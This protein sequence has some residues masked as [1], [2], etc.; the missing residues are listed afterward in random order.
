[1]LGFVTNPCE[2]LSRRLW[3]TFLPLNHLQVPQRN[4]QTSPFTFSRSQTHSIPSKPNSFT[5]SLPSP[6]RYMINWR[7]IKN[8]KKNFFLFVHLLTSHYNVRV[9]KGGELTPCQ[10]VVKRMR[11]GFPNVPLSDVCNCRKTH[12][13][14]SNSVLI[15]IMRKPVLLLRWCAMHRLWVWSWFGSFRADGVN[16]ELWVPHSWPIETFLR[17]EIV[18]QTIFWPNLS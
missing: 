5:C 3:A 13:K 6:V 7:E 10:L 1:M 8:W 4:S 2:S 18:Q 12:G 15:T 11:K 17:G 14:G 9:R 16:L